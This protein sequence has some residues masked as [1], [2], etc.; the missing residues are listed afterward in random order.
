MAKDL[1]GSFGSVPDRRNVEGGDFREQNIRANP[2]MFGAQV[3]AAMVRSGAQA[4]RTGQEG[5]ELATRYEAQA[6]EARVNDDYAN[7]YIPRALELRNAYD[8][9]EGQDK[10]HGYENY[11]KGI[12]ELNNEFREQDYGE[13]GKSL[14]R[15]LTNRTLINAQE[16]GSR[17]LAQASHALSVQAATDRAEAEMNLGAANYNDPVIVGQAW[18]AISGTIE[19]MAID[20]GI[21][22][23]TPEGKERVDSVLN[24]ARGEFAAKL[25][26]SAVA[27]GDVQAAN[28]IYAADQSYIPAYQQER[29]ESVLRVENLRQTGENSARALI[30]GAVMPEPTGMPKTSV[31]AQVAD[32]WHDAGLDPNEGLALAQVESAMGTITGKR[33]TIGQDYDSQGKPLP[34]QIASMRKYWIEAKGT[35]ERT[36]GRQP[37]GWEAYAVYQQGVGGGPALLNAAMNSP[38]AKAIDVLAPLYKKRSIAAEAITANGG[39]LTMTAGDFLDVIKGKYE[40]AAS[41]S[42]S[43]LP[44]GVRPGESIQRPYQQATETVQPA[45]TPLQALNEFQAKLPAKLEFINSVK[46]DAVRAELKKRLEGYEGVYRAQAEAYKTQ[47]TTQVQSYQYS[48]DFVS[49]DQVP[50]PLQAT[51]R[52]EF[53]KEWMDLKLAADTHRGADPNPVAIGELEAR[54][55]NL[56]EVTESKGEKK[57][58]VKDGALSDAVRLQDDIM[59]ASDQGIIDGTTAKAMI[60]SIQVNMGTLATN[61]AEGGGIFGMSA[62]SPEDSHY[63][64]AFKQFVES[65]ATPTEVSRMFRDYVAL[66]D[67]NKFDDV[68]KKEPPFYQQAFESLFGGKQENSAPKAMTPERAVEA[69]KTAQAQKRYQGLVMLPSTPNAVIGR[70]GSTMTMN[71]QPPQG[72]ADS[73]LGIKS[74]V[75]QD[76]NGNKAIVYYNSN[77]DVIKIQEL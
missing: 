8:A 18:D 12:Q 65:G 28:S 67:E 73:T 62:K 66:S 49:M 52:K 72:S 77:G 36:L 29:I 55:Q 33:G 1:Y 42:R 56:F 68:T 16:T 13:Y 3:G 70:D 69:I 24:Q 20:N 27:R 26:D 39:N 71:T 31:Q 9:L 51:L 61:S 76:A 46:N 40:R 7:K 23:A 17:E 38:A 4:V 34:D 74:E 63:G 32:S 75:R 47:I 43:S 19:M 58:K 5:M 14:W 11:I 25:L 15:D 2:D 48:P 64:E 37:A 54:T 6:T 30:A 22:P 57:V 45:A 60:K 35:A 10:V 44:V 41:L 59:T 53:P 50:A 21:D